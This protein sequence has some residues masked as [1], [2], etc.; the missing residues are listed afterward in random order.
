MEALRHDDTLRWCG[1]VLRITDNPDIATHFVVGSTSECSTDN[2]HARVR[3]KVLVPFAML[4]HAH[5][6][7][8]GIRTMLP[9]VFDELPLRRRVQLFKLFVSEATCLKHHKIVGEIK[10]LAEVQPLHRQPVLF[11]ILPTD[12]G[13]LCAELSSCDTDAQIRKYKLILTKEEVQAHSVAI[14]GAIRKAPSNIMGM[15]LT[16]SQFIAVIGIVKS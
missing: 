6:S 4:R 7:R 13:N 3:M 8:P 10:R 5:C 2:L 9:V 16:M 14:G 15:C 12:I 11:E 1:R